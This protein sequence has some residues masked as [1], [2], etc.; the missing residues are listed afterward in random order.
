MRPEALEERPPLEILGDVRMKLARARQVRQ[1]VCR[2]TR[3]ERVPR[4]V[5]LDV[6]REYVDP[7]LPG[8]LRHD[9]LAIAGTR[10]HVHAESCAVTAIARG[11]ASGEREPAAEEQA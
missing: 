2:A 11:H 6:R 5:Q 1:S 7:G 3:G 8:V 9:P 4:V 10:G